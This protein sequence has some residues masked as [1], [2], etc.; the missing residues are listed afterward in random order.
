MAHGRGLAHSRCLHNT[1]SCSLVWGLELWPGTSSV[2]CGQGPGFV[3]SIAFAGHPGV[4]QRPLVRSPM[5]HQD[6]CSPL[7]LVPASIHPPLQPLL[8][9]A[10]S[11]DS[12]K[13]GSGQVPLLLKTS[14]SHLEMIFKAP[15]MECG[16]FPDKSIN[17]S[18]YKSISLK[19]CN[20]LAFE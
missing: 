17:L 19:L 6:E 12:K 13:H 20:V 5:A 7:H 11:L 2:A 1:W 3:I 14:R 16:V 15:S 10:A 4:H 18:R 9:P 8:H